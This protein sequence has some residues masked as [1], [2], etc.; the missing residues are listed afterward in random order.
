LK[1]REREKGGGGVKV[2]KKEGKKEDEIVSLILREVI[3]Y[4][5]SS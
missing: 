1:E 2:R 5:F 3:T 4:L